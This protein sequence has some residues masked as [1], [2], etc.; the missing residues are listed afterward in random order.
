MAGT[1]GSTI[2][3]PPAEATTTTSTTSTTSTTTTAAPG[4][5]LNVAILG[6]DACLGPWVEGLPTYSYSGGTTL[7]DCTSLNA[8]NA[9]SLSAGSYFVSDGTDF[10]NFISPGGGS[11]L[12]TASGPCVS[13]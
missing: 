6:G 9:V 8:A 2:T 5:I 1:S 13:C 3:I 7:C 12:L 11:T 4:P 10:R